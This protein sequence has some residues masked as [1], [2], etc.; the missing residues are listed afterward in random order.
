MRFLAD[1]HIHSHYSLA[2]SK[3]L[4]PAKLD[5]WGRIK[6]IHL[7]G[8]GDFTHPKWTAEMQPQFEPA[9]D[10]L[11]KIKN[12]YRLTPK[13]FGF[14]PA[15]AACHFVLSAEISCI[16]KKNGKTRK[17]HIIL[18]APSF[19]TAQKLQQKLQQL[20]FNI[21]SDGRPI[22]GLD[23]YKL[24]AM[25]LEID[26]RIMFIPAH[27]W[28][29]W[30]SVLGDK[31]GF[32]S[33]EECFE[34]LTP[35]IF[36]LEMGL[37]SDPP[38]N[39]LVGD[40][41][42]FTLIANSDA[43]SPEKLGRNANVFNTE[44]S[45]NGLTNALK[46]GKSEVFEGTINF[47]PQEGKYHYDGHRKCN[48][49]FSPDET[50]KHNSICPVCKTK[51]TVGVLNRIANLA[52]RNTIEERPNKS[53]FRSLIPLKEILA[54]LNNTKETAKAV[55]KQYQEI[56]DGCESEFDLLLNMPINDI[57]KQKGELLALAI[58]RMRN[59]QIFVTEGYDGEFGQIKIVSEDEA[60]QIKNKKISIEIFKL[61]NPPTR[62]LVSF[63]IKAFRE[64][65]P[66]KLPEN[67]QLKLF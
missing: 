32:D 2:T 41:D 60:K 33:I 15:L 23:A 8:T 14:N 30:F 12:E 21:T 5:L 51:L 42:R 39:W 53:T 66:Q 40:L 16:Y 44:L 56:L 59:R 24:L 29:P 11:Y 34:D 3:E 38:I 20:N 67:K 65:M 25:C 62:P 7:I 18:L 31:S 6:G 19:E 64:N 4:V 13:D 9:A 63:D 35:H 57:A 48:I 17:V 27:I 55:I 26:E 28:T 52:T 47:F 37:S 58:E 54:Q 45:Y 43:H 10:G 22:L 1:L 61:N 46:S 50:V 49:C 36:A